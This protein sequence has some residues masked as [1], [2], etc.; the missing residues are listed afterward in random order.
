MAFTLSF[1]RLFFLDTCSINSVF[2][3]SLE[4]DSVSVAC[5]LRKSS[6]LTFSA[7]VSDR[8][9]SAETRCLRRAWR[10]ASICLS[11]TSACKA[12]LI[13][14]WNERCWPC[15]LLMISLLDVRV[16]TE[17]K[18]RVPDASSSLRAWYLSK[19]SLS[20][21]FST[22]AWLLCILNLWASAC[23]SDVASAAHLAMDTHHV[24]WLCFFENVE[25][26]RNMPERHLLVDPEGL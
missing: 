6:S 17:L 11:T 9:V 7:I 13:W 3:A 10:C 14:F 24:E 16:Q 22:R 23:K 20:R 18:Q 2:L 5:S 1:S 19:S 26:L 21:S 4:F 8:F 12:V 25:V 15:R